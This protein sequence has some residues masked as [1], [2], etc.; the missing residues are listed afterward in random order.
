[1]GENQ[2]S[3]C[4]EFQNACERKR[5]RERERDPEHFWRE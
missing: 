3:H 5:E 1:M 4:C 2:L